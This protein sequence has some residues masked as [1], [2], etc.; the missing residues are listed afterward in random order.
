[1]EWRLLY[2]QRSY[3]EE[4]LRS[5]GD[6]PPPVELQPEQSLLEFET[7]DP[8]YRAL[9]EE[10]NVW[11]GLGLYRAALV[12][13]RVLVENLLID[14]LRGMYGMKDVSIFYN[15]ARGRSHSL[16]TLI[17][18][19][20]ERVVDVKPLD[21]GLEDGLFDR[22]LELTDRGDA[23][24]HALSVDAKEFLLR[25]KPTLQRIVRTLRR[26][27]AELRTGRSRPQEGSEPEAARFTRSVV[28][29]IA[30]I[31][32]ATAPLGG[33]G[34]SRSRPTPSRSIPSRS[35][36]C[37]STL[38]QGGELGSLRLSAAAMPEPRRSFGSPRSD[39][40]MPGELAQSLGERPIS[41]EMAV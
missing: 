28:H 33:G 2:R 6:K 23:G 9:L 12:L 13:S 10:I 29:Q 22:A 5:T 31:L 30:P 32:S 25:F 39:K 14:L 20:R 37:P 4:C 19:A 40:L 24:A 26:A 11:Y 1:M 21:S 38:E 16:T 8:F 41:F 15:K 27:N 34:G 7:D 36:S 17:S 3:D 35:P 18:N